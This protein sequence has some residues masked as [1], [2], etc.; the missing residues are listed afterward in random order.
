MQDQ[1]TRLCYELV[2]AEDPKDLYP[3]SEHLQEA[4]HHHV[5]RL[6]AKAPEFMMIDRVVDLDRGIEVSSRS[7]G[8]SRG[9]SG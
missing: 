7:P 3:A 9:H 4:N 6:R 2:W 8:S 1:I 5:E